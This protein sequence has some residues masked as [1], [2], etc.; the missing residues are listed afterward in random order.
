MKYWNCILSVLVVIVLL[1]GGVSALGEVELEIDIPEERKGLQ[2][3]IETDDLENVWEEI[4][5]EISELSLDVDIPEAIPVENILMD[6]DGLPEEVASALPNASEGVF[7]EIKKGK[8]VKYNGPGGDVVIP[9]GVTSIGGHAFDGCES[10]TSVTIPDSVTLIEDGD[11]YYDF[12]GYDVESGAFSNCVNLSGISFPD[13]L[14]SIGDGA[15]FGCSSLSHVM[16]PGNVTTIGVGA[17]MGCSNLVDITVPDGVNIISD[18]AF[19]GCSSLINV[20]IP[21][22]IIKI[23]LEAFKD[24]I[25][26]ESITLSNQLTTIGKAAFRGCRGLTSITIPSSVIDIQGDEMVYYGAGD[27]PIKYPG[28][29]SGCVQ[30]ASVSFPD[31]TINMGYGIFD[32]CKSLTN[33]KIPNGWTTISDGSFAGCTGLTSV[34]I[35]DSV[36]CIGVDAFKNCTCLTSVIIS[37]SVTTIKAGTFSGCTDLTSV[38]IPNSL[39]AIEG[40]PQPEQISEKA[41]LIDGAFEGCTGLKSITIPNSVTSIGQNAF[42]GCTGLTS[43]TIPNSVTYIDRGTFSGCNGL[44]SIIIPDGVTVIQ[45]CYDEKGGSEW[46]QPRFYIPGAFEDCTSLSSITIPGSVKTIGEGAFGN[47]SE[48]ATFQL[49]CGGYTVKWAKQN[50]Y[51]YT[52]SDHTPVADPAVEPTYTKAGKTEGSHCS[53]CGKVLVAQEEVPVKALPEDGLLMTK[54]CGKKLH[55]GDKRQIVLNTGSAEG[56][57]SSNTRIVTVSEK[58]VL[59]AK[60]A[61]TAKITVTRT[62]GDKWVLTVKV[63]KGSTLSRTKATLKRGKTLALKVD[64]LDGRKVTWSSSDKKIATVKDGK[65]TAVKAGKCVISAKVKYGKTLKCTVTVV[66]PEKLSA[67]KLKLVVNKTA[68]LKLAG[69]SGQSVTWTTSNAKVA[70]LTKKGAK[71]AT[72]KAVGKGTATISAK[73]EGGPILKCKVVVSTR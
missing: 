51:Q 38:M 61:G 66:N 62:D 4:P 2:L 40:F 58:G 29:F 42:R 57:R 12:N 44:T 31:S 16:I 63:V 67:T 37:N 20:I 3:E 26:I 59:T 24:C 32:G 27:E 18:K 52:L 65:V 49:P 45:G 19:S 15:F 64:D 70:K 55:Q 36:I 43:V 54:S 47:I 34:T 1:C 11:I 7:F 28:A 48:D 21:N 13:G 46:Y 56:Y 22:N 23:G 53:V 71:S 33:I 25:S 60:K 17:F 68:V 39:I 10:L 50:N 9:K 14:V 8:L 30:L 72:V 41:D 5:A 73:I 69:L 35:P 6:G